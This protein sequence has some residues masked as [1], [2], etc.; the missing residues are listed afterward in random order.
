MLSW[1][2]LSE[3]ASKKEEKAIITK[4]SGKDRVI[5]IVLNT[6]YGE[7]EHIEYIEDDEE[8][9]QIVGD[10]MGKE[11]KEYILSM[12]EQ[13]NKT[14]DLIEFV[15]DSMNDLLDFYKDYIE[16]IE[17]CTKE[18]E[19]EKDY[20]TKFY[21]LEGGIEYETLALNRR[22]ERKVTTINK[23]LENYLKKS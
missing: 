4:V 22:V 3:K 13:K 8:F 23:K 6:E 1:K 9:A 5:N 2:E 12:I 10:Y 17:H 20:E 16:D 7:E 18:A 21:K 11:S 15:Q 19:A 14:I